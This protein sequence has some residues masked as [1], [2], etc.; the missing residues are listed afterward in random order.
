MPAG[1]GA[2]SAAAAAASA[3][4]GGSEQQRR[5]WAQFADHLDTLSLSSEGTGAGDD[6]WSITDEQ[7]DYY[8]AQFRTM[9]DDLRGVISGQWTVSCAP[10]DMHR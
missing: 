5:E 2:S 1:A 6:A 7:R 4:V 9:Q 8:V 3:V 10:L